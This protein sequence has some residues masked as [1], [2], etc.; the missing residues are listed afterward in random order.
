MKIY[1]LQEEKEEEEE[2]NH[3]HHQQQ[4]HKEIFS[5]LKKEVPILVQEPYRQDSRQDQKRNSQQHII[6]KILNVQRQNSKSYKGKR[7]SN[8]KA[9]P[10]EQ[11]PTSQ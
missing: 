11:H 2:E 5:N 3:D 9:D 7:P 4:N 6:I 8:I 1:K 10:L